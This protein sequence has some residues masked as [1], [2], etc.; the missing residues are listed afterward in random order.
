LD[1]LLARWHSNAGTAWYLPDHLGTV[2]DIVDATGAIINH[3]DYDSF[4]RLVT[5]TN[6]VVGDR[7]G[8]TGREYDP[9]LAL[10]YYRARHYD[11]QL[12]RFVSQDPLGF[13][14]GDSNL[15][16][17]VGNAP[18]TAR[19][20]LGLAGVALFHGLM[21]GGVLGF[22][23]GWVEGFTEVVVSPEDS[24]APDAL[25]VARQRAIS[26]GAVGTI[27]GGTLAALPSVAQFYGG[28]ILSG[29]AAGLI[30]GR[31]PK[32]PWQV[33]AVRVGCVVISAA[34]GPAAQRGLADR[35]GRLPFMG[36]RSPNAPRSP[37]PPVPRG[38]P[39]G[40]PEPTP[41]PKPPGAKAN[42]E[43]APSRP[44]VDAPEAPMA[45]RDIAEKGL[46]E[47]AATA[48]K[49]QGDRVYALRPS[50]GGSG[51]LRWRR[52]NRPPP[53][54]THGNSLSNSADT[55]IYA[56]RDP[57]GRAYKIGE[58]AKGVRVGD[59][60][61]MRAEQQV[62]ELIREYGPGF[63]SQVRHQGQMF[64]GKAAGRSYETKFIRTFRRFFGDDKLPGNL[65]DR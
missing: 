37:T 4:G 17:Y 1:N 48:I 12:G 27:L 6:P 61:S 51:P 40:V 7:F 2:R 44:S 31:A 45:S 49:I 58:S 16:R 33:T 15:Y 21:A 18:L 11:P 54:S 28:G 46:A 10:Y 30:I 60:Q 59:G 35:I 22:A 53:A 19:D 23:C 52:M 50:N 57:Q 32:D 47:Y 65:T 55:H 36:G 29:V 25:T 9:E 62:R 43:P 63:T 34:I 38:R 13:A 26:Y 14:V 64:P 42:P 5:Q 20:P 56:I 3:L 39:N 8:F 24:D 41:T